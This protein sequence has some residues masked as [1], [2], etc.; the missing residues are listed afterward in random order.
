MKLWNGRFGINSD[1]K[2]D[3]YNASISFDIKLLPYDV[4]ASIAHVTTLKQANVLTSEE[5]EILIIGLEKINEEY[6]NGQIEFFVEDEDVHML[7]ERLLT[8]KVGELGKKVHTGRSRNDQVATATRLYTIDKLH[9]LYDCLESWID[10]LDQQSLRYLSDIMAGCTHLQAAQP[11]TLGFWFDAYKQMFIRDL[12]KLENCL[13]SMNQCPLGSAALAG[14]SYP[15]DRYLTAN[16]LGFKQPT[17]N[18]MDSVADRDYIADSLYICTLIGVH[19]SKISE[20]LIIFNS[21]VYNYITL[22]DRY[23]TGSSIMPQKKN[24]DI[25]E[26]ARGKSARMIGNLTQLLT[27]IK[28]T[29]LAYNKDFQEDKESLFDSIENTTLALELF[30]PMIETAKFNTEK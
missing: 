14:T 8:L 22:D 29:P 6:Q 19:L 11:I 16:I 20:E 5:S 24:P 26:L 21:Q 13:D 1:S 18:S 3:M 10:C 17:A 9:Y 15:L 7:I 4:K 12:Q 2:T 30:I 27:M 23:S 25:A 28:G